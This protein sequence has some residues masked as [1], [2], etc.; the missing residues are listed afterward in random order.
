MN[1]NI[2][3]MN[4]YISPMNLTNESSQLTSLFSVLL[5]Y[6]IANTGIEGDRWIIE[7]HTVYTRILYIPSG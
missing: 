5:N 2:S 7:L 4:L 1:L 3:P 6:I